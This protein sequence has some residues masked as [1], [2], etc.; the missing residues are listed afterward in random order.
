MARTK[1]TDEGFRQNLLAKES[2]MNLD[3]TAT[4]VAPKTV[5][6]WKAVKPDRKALK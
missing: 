2:L 5:R 3:L 4:S 6:E 1:I